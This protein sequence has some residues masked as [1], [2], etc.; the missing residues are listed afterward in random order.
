MRI[1]ELAETTGVPVHTLKYYLREGLLMP[2]EATSR[3]R[4]EYGAEHVERVRLVRALVEH[5]GV[6]IA[7]VHSILAALAAPPPSHHE[8]LGVAHCALPTPGDQGPV[9]EEVGALVDDLGWPVWPEAPALRALSAAVAAA[10]AAGVELSTGSLHRYAAAMA[11]V[12]AVDLDVALAAES[13]AAAMHTVVVGT[14][15][16]DPVLVALRRLAQESVSARRG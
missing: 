11:D 5:S 15:M 10:R 6:G 8:L 3:T 4:A 16:V 1:S 7:G 12:A 2:G 9:S 13:P 14:V